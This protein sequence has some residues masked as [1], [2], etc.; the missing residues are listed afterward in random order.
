MGLRGWPLLGAAVRSTCT[1]G[2][3]VCQT[4]NAMRDDSWSVWS[5]T[6]V[7]V[8]CREAVCLRLQSCWLNKSCDVD[9]VGSNVLHIVTLEQQTVSPLV[10]LVIPPLLESSRETEV[11]R[12]NCSKDVVAC[13][14]AIC[15]ASAELFSHA[16]SVA[17][18]PAAPTWTRSKLT[19]PLQRL[20]GCLW[21]RSR[22]AQAW[23]V[24]CATS[25]AKSLLFFSKPSPSV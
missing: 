12:M 15:M 25:A 7:Q 4:R 20:K 11:D 19:M 5:W 21:C 14:D 24:C 1:D 9:I 6:S 10:K 2:T 22:P 13:A 18:K 8:F 16:Q 23:P 3:G 17:N